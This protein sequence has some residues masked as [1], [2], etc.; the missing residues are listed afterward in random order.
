M[1]KPATEPVYTVSQINREARTLLEAGFPALWVSGEISNLARPAS[2]HW[3]FSLKDERAQ[4]RCAMFRNAGLRVRQRPENGQQVLVR[5]RVSLYEARGDYQ[6]IVE[7]L[8]PAGD[9][10]LLRRLEEL[11]A[12][13]AAEGLFDPGSKRPLPALPRRIGVVTSASGAAVRDILQILRRRFPA[14][15]V[16]LYPVA[17]QG[18]NAKFE[19][20]AALRTAGERRDCDVLIL[21]R[22]GGSLEDLWAFNEESV[23]RAIRACPLPVVSGIGHEIDFTLADLAADLR[24][25]TPSGA[26]ELV[27]PD[28]REWAGRLR[29]LERHGAAALRLTLDRQLSHAAQLSQRLERTHPDFVLRQRSQR[30]DELLGRLGRGALRLVERHEARCR[31]ATARLAGASPRAH[32]EGCGGELGR[33]RLRLDNAM[34]R[35]LAQAGQRLAL[36][37]ASLQAF[38]PLR[39]L[40]R[41]YAI[42]TDSRSARVL[43]RARDAAPGQQI[44]TRLAEGSLEATVTRIAD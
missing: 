35:V 29:N 25:P 27:V 19:V 8:E 2:G 4:V 11:K 3:Y 39:T 7:H 26:A 37:A 38:S 13:L 21:A 14:I 18:E 36:T 40:E 30:L 17:V 5:A 6:L 16:V 43:T 22:G 20:A 32:L 42:V 23:V 33:L 12:R 31:H 10:L 9:G 41:G 24:A 15:P 28:W 1:E 44:T 34:Q